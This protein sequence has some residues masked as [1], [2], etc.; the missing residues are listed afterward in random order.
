MAFAC[1]I[2]LILLC[3]SSLFFL[4]T[5]GV[6]DRFVVSDCVGFWPL[7]SQLPFFWLN[8]LRAKKLSADIGRRMPLHQIEATILVLQREVM[9]QPLY[10]F[11]KHTFAHFRVPHLYKHNDIELFDN[12]RN[13][14]SLF[15][16]CW[17]IKP[18]VAAKSLYKMLNIIKTHHT[19][20]FMKFSFVHYSPHLIKI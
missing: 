3:V 6:M 19:L 17:L 10:I 5:C 2:L 15:S 9:T 8:L 13:E 16:V 1:F 12:I 18:V 14:N 7:P 20:R 11:Y 4:V